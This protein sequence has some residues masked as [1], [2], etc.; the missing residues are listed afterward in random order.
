MDNYMVYVPHNSSNK[1]WAAENRSFMTKAEIK[2][3]FGVL[4]NR[5]RW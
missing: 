5:R 2:M 4:R 3:R 1:K